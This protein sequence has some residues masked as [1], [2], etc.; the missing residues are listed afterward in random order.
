M[1]KQHDAEIFPSHET[2]PW[3]GWKHAPDFYG[4]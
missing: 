1:A 3:M 4:A 2:A